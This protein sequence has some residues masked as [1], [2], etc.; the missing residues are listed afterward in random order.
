MEATEVKF[1]LNT[2]GSMNTPTSIGGI[3][4]VIRDNHGN[5]VIGF[6]GSLTTTIPIITEISALV[7]GL[8]V[9]KLH[10]LTPIEIS[11]DCKEV[12]SYLKVDHPSYSNI[13]SDC[14]DLIK[15]MGMPPVHHSYQEENKVAD[16]LAKEGVKLKK[17]N[18]ILI[19]SVPPL[20]AVKYLES[21][22][23]GT[24]F[25][26]RLSPTS[27]NT[28]CNQSPPLTTHDSYNH[29]MPLSCTDAY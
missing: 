4:G 1:K 3:G 17:T 24:L 27:I 5:W 7:K 19:L 28:K 12:I 11:I 8:R 23:A 10:N 13:L 21:D 9:A 18:S 14:R 22:K 6:M 16:I 26:R 20:F 15:Q 25:V 29:V 2:D